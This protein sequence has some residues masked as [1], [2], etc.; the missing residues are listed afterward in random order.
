MSF[1]SLGKNAI[2]ALNKGAKMAGC[3]HNTGEG[4]VS[5]YH[6]LGGDI[7]WQLG[8]AYFGARDK[9]G[10]FS[11]APFNQSSGRAEIND[12]TNPSSFLTNGDPGG[13]NI[14]NV[15]DPGLTIQFTFMNVHCRTLI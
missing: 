15:T 7:V 3:Y 14:F 2:S 12:N 13:L 11:M 1:G 4:G 5:P 6:K 9:N 10:N 8:T